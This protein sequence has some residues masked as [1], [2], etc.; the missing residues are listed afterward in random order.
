MENSISS[1]VKYTRLYESVHYLE[2][3]VVYQYYLA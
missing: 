2:S 3:L 1:S